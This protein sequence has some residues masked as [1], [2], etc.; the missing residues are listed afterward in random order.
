MNQYWGPRKEIT[1]SVR[2]L[3]FSRNCTTQY[4]NCKRVRV[5]VKVSSQTNQI[6]GWKGWGRGFTT[7]TLL[8][9]QETPLPHPRRMAAHLR[10][11]HTQGLDFVKWKQD[12]DEK[13]LVLFLQ[14][15]GKAIDDARSQGAFLGPK[16][17][18]QAQCAHP[19]VSQGIYTPHSHLPRISRSS[20]IPL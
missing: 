18:V 7:T 16:A 2:L 15:Q 4:A 9:Q 1:G 3:S 14:G 13:H 8:W 5:E 10:V 12:T 17:Y 11:V 20:A 6:P 19:P